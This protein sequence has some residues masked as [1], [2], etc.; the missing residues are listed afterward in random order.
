MSTTER[1]TYAPFHI[2]VEG[3]LHGQ[4]WSLEHLVQV[5]QHQLDDY[6]YK[7]RETVRGELSGK[8]AHVWRY[9]H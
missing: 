9:M 8:V 4:C 6:V 2:F 5:G 3:P 1:A 7:Y